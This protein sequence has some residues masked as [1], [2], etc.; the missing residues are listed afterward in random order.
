MTDFIFSGF[1]GQGALTAG[2]ILVKAGMEF[3]KQV[4]WIPSYGSE[5]R[6]GTANCGVKVSDRKIA[7]P[8]VKDIDVLVAMNIPSLDKF[9]ATVR[10][11]GL[12]VANESMCS[13]YDFKKESR[14]FFVPATSI[15]GQLEN[16]R[17]ANIV[18]LGA[19]AGVWNDI[20]SQAVKIGLRLF[21]E[22]KRAKYDSKNDACFDRG[23]AEV[24]ERC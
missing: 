17:G 15:A 12:I 14:V 13:A 18:M 21:F 19:L 4:S 7:S 5:M 23:L 11:G 8:F 9:E 2:L 24:K 6:G 16:T 22:E 10:P 20:P 3:G 1:G